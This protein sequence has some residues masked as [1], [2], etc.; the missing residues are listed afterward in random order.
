MTGAIEAVGS[1]KNGLCLGARG[2]S[3]EEWEEEW[4]EEEEEE[5]EEED[6]T[7]HIDV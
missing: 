1:C 6:V 2:E 3:E 5:E 7:D 4:E